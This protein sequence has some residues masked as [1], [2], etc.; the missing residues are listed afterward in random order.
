MTGP[1]SY[2]EGAN[3]AIYE[4]VGGE[5]N[6]K[7]DLSPVLEAKAVKNTVGINLLNKA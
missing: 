4:A 5:A 2:L 6:V 7:F 1:S 3:Y